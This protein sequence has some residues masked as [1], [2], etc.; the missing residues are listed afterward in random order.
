M[1]TYTLNSGWINETYVLE[2]YVVFTFFNLCGMHCTFRGFALILGISVENGLYVCVASKEVNTHV[3][4][5]KVSCLC[6]WVLKI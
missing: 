3:F 6:Y 4:P 2:I 5:V 1:R